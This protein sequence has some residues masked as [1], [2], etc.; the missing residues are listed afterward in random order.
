M[1]SEAYAVLLQKIRD[2]YRQAGT[3]RPSRWVHEGASSYTVMIHRGHA[4]QDTARGG[5]RDGEASV[6]MSGTPIQPEICSKTLPCPRV[7]GRSRACARGS[8]R[9][10]RACCE[11]L[12]AVRGGWTCTSTSRSPKA[13]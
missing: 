12:G 11:A 5:G 4:V 10:R 9:A 1:V 2:A 13:T 6:T 3:L 7:R 8:R